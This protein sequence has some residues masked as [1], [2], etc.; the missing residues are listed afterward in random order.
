[1]EVFSRD[2]H[3]VVGDRNGNGVWTTALHGDLNLTTVRHGAESIIDDVQQHLLKLPAVAVNVRQILGHFKFDRNIPILRLLPLD[4]PIVR[5][6]ECL[7]I[8]P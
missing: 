4:K 1:M 7:N 3:S 2:A 5:T 8:R 6:V